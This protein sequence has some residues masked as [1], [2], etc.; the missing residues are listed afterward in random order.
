MDIQDKLGRPMVNLEEKNFRVYE[1]GK[2][3]TTGREA[4]AARPQAVRRAVC[5]AAHRHERSDRRLGGHA[6]AGFGGGTFRRSTGRDAR[7]RG[8]ARSTARRRSRRSWVSAR[9]WTPRRSSRR[10]VSSARA[11][12][13]T[14]L[15]GAVF[16]GL[17]MLKR[18]AGRVEGHE[19]GRRA[20]DLHRPR[21]SGPQRQPGGPEGGRAGH[22]GGD[23]PDRRRREDQP[24]GADRDRTQRRLLSDNPK[25][26]KRG[27]EDAIKKLAGYSEGKYVFAYCSPKRRGSHKLEIEVVTS[28][29]NG[30]LHAEVQRRRLQ[31]GLRAQDEAGIRP[32]RKKRP[33]ARRTARPTPRPPK[34]RKEKA[35]A[36]SASEGH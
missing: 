34:R 29:E 24:R 18:A 20:G 16:Q 21:R 35:F 13:T 5:A 33:K 6:R 10:C 9:R 17:H 30:R 2:L 12:A 28:K 19:E 22:A 31:V 32:S 1:N 8:R 27:F 26:F 14:N 3:V 7:D 4:G 15:N 25:E 11:A 23:L 36:R